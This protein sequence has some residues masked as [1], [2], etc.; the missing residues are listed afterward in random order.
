MSNQEYSEALKHPKWQKKRLQ[1]LELSKF[2]CN[3]CGDENKSLHVHHTIY[4][5]NKKPWEYPDH[6]FMVLCDTCHERLH[7]MKQS[8]ADSIAGQYSWEKIELF[9]YM[10][11][12]EAGDIDVM[13]DFFQRHNEYA[14]H[15]VPR[16]II[17]MCKM[18]DGVLPDE[19]ELRLI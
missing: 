17:N 9:G 5:K 16:I 13:R 1:I 19:D 3:R 2:G 14:V 6:E 18:L 15:Y 12:M 10:S 7:K 4:R 11:K 8:L